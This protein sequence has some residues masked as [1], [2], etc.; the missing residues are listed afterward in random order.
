MRI[1]K[2]FAAAAFLV[3][4]GA[5]CAA[6]QPTA[7]PPTSAPE[8]AAPAAPKA[9]ELTGE[10]T[11]GAIYP[12]TGD[13]AAY[14]LPL[15][16]ATN[17]AVDEI[18]AN[19]G[20]APSLASDRGVG[21]KKLVVAYEDGKCDGRASSVAAEKLI[22][23]MNVSAI[24]GGGC[25]G[26]TLGIAPAANEY[27]R[28]VISPSETSSDITTKGGDYVFRFAPSDALAG[29]A[30]AFYALKN[31][32]AKHAAII[33]EK[34][35]DA[36]AL[37]NAFF[38]AFDKNGGGVYVDEAY[39]T[40][41]TD[42][43]AIALKIKSKNVDVVYVA[44]QTP[45]SG[46]AIMKALKSQKIT[47][48]ILTT[49]VMTGVDVAKNNADLLEGVMSFAPFFDVNSTSARAFIEKYKATYNED[50]AFPSIVANAYSET[51]LLKELIAANG[52][53]GVRL[54]A[55]LASLSNWSGGA[56]T[57]VTLDKNGDIAWKA[58]SVNQVTGGLTT[59]VKTFE[60][61]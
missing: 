28:A 43:R 55:A 19:G 41:T 11:V 23:D 7:V 4:F 10:V 38:D 36:Q 58:F 24:M 53:E 20:V 3:A 51:Y 12:L 47:A 60:I 59:E 52:A 8:A 1:T 56:L 13:A 22:K 42:F 50:P 40:G 27:K 31:L 21:G 54:Q 48:K 34:T 49:A 14:G 39:K 17:L 5:G 2:F 35:D 32:A 45:E 44:P 33:S 46:T 18:N 16:K 61:E 15:Q 25:P 37:R 57:N 26:E 29:K 30:A 9:P 6:T